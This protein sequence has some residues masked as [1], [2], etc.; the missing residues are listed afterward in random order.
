MS[1]RTLCR[2]ILSSRHP[3]AH[4][5]ATQTG[6][7]L[8]QMH[9]AG[10]DDSAVR[11]ANWCVAAAAAAASVVWLSPVSLFAEEDE[12]AQHWRKHLGPEAKLMDLSRRK[13]MLANRGTDQQFI[14]QTC[15]GPRAIED[16][17]IFLC[18]RRSH[19][20]KIS[21]IAVPG[22]TRVCAVLRVGDI[23][24]G[25]H[26]LL[27]GGFT[28]AILDDMTGVTAWLEK[29]AQGLGSA[30]KIFTANLNVNYRRPLPH[31]SEYLVDVEVD[32]FEKGKKVFLTGTIY[33]E[34]G[35]ACVQATALYIVKQ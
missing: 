19:D 4:V 13:A 6:M 26:G 5:L 16:C 2:R 14:W 34:Q 18:D 3:G 28:A 24:N 29:E 31:N 12:V 33:D 30:P 17:K 27:H 21:E 1:G 11:S 22:K 15:T 8:R 32:R 23:L 25:H 35:N 7:S 9:A 20:N 10:A